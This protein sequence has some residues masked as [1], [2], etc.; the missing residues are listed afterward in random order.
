MADQ[1][2]ALGIPE[3]IG[4]VRIKIMVQVMTE[5]RGGDR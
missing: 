1:S 4:I 3:E 2:L 5:V